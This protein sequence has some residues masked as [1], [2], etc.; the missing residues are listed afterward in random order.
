MEDVAWS[1]RAGISETWVTV[2]TL[3]EARLFD[4][5]EAGEIRAHNW[6]SRQY[7]S[8]NS[9]S[10]VRRHRSMKQSAHTEGAE[11][12]TFPK[13]SNVVTVTPS[14]QNRTDTEQSIPPLP[15]R[16]PKRSLLADEDKFDD[17]KVVATEA[18]MDGSTT[19][20]GEA[21]IE[22]RRLDWTQ[23]LA[24]IDGVKARTGTD[25]PAI[26]ALPQNYM[27]K[28][29]WERKIRTPPEP[30]FDPMAALRQMVKEKAL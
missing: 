9:T 3:I 10:R 29:M 21:R 18:G 19:D 14:E 26:T 30:K 28:R 12:E 25:D 17:F 23:R 2:N 22:W 11:R 4:R 24:A 15:P 16:P 5:D 13:R 1:L 6:D 8:D 27:R 20:W 7:S